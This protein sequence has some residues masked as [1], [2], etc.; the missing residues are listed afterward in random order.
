MVAKGEERCKVGR[1]KLFCSCFKL[2][3]GCFNMLP[4]RFNLL[5]LR[6]NTL[7]LRSKKLSQPVEFV[8]S[9]GDYGDALSEM[10]YSEPWLY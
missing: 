8:I 4:L 10:D 2:L 3:F 9:H 6:F 7:L 5:L 1:R